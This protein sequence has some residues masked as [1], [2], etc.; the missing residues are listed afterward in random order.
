M[1]GSQNYTSL[2]VCGC[3]CAFCELQNKTGGGVK[4]RMYCGGECGRPSVQQWPRCSTW[5]V[6]RLCHRRAS[7]SFT[8]IFHS[9]LLCTLTSLSS[10][11]VCSVHCWMW[12]SR[13]HTDCVFTVCLRLSV[14]L[15]CGTDTQ[16][17]RHFFHGAGMILTCTVFSKV[18]LCLYSSLSLRSQIS[19]WMREDVQCVA[20]HVCM[21]SCECCVSGL[22]GDTTVCCSHSCFYTFAFF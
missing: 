2:G 6:T 17:P 9:R 11:C 19:V 7:A 14:S 4:V 12:A 16:T 22:I 5:A 10:T 3:Q 15:R 18:D 8:L 1:H 20:M 21:T 13:S